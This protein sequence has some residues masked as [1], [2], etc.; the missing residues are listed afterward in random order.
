[1][2][3]LS[4]ASLALKSE[5]VIIKVRL[6]LYLV[7]WLVVGPNAA[8][9]NGMDLNLNEPRTSYTSYALLLIA[10]YLSVHNIIS[11]TSLKTIRHF[12]NI[13]FY[14]HRIF[15]LSFLNFYCLSNIIELI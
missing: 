6:G 9:S 15:A 12:C 2:G 4:H 1:M 11:Q 5:R 13:G 8:K 3:S 14:E 10:E 7:E